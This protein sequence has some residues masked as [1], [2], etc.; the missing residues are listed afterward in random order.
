[1][2]LV[3]SSPLSRAIQTS[4]V[5]FDHSPAPVIVHPDLKELKKDYTF[6][7]RYPAGKPGCSGIPGSSLRDAVSR[8][9]RASTAPVDT[10]LLDKRGELW[11]DPTQSHQSQL[12]E[13]EG[14][15]DWLS[16]RPE[17]RIAVV[18]GF[19]IIIIIN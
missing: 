8:H 3:V 11:F 7:G 17:K 16:N 18:R 10:S 1:M 6:N 15:V 2:Q 13:L 9:P 19:V 14:F 5:A 4:I 12:D